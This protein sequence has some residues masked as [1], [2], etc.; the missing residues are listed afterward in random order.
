MTLENG[1]LVVSGEKDEEFEERDDQR[2]CWRRQ[3]LMN[4][5]ACGCGSRVPA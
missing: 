2:Q 1:A 5:R 4:V 3:W